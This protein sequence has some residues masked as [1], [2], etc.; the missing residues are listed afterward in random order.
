MPYP[1][2]CGNGASERRRGS[3]KCSPMVRHRS[4]ADL[5]A[6]AAGSGSPDMALMSTVK[7]SDGR[8]PVAALSKTRPPKRASES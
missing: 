1:I 7:R 5:R 6:T 2:H 3:A 8:D 4:C